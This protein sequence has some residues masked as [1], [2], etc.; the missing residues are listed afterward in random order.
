MED[1]NGYC[2]AFEDGAGPSANT[3]NGRQATQEKDYNSRYN[4]VMMVQNLTDFK[5]KP[6]NNAFN[7]I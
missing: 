4:E 5:K 1:E 7:P 3:K 6:I 2:G